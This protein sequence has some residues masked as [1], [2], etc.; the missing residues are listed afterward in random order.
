MK[1]IEFQAELNGS[2]VLQ[3][4]AE[5][6]SKLPDHGTATV[7]VVVDGEADDKAWRQAAREQFMR[8]DSKADA[9]Y[10]RYL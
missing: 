1:P 9:S 3:I 8:D 6:A 10:D 4:P 2:R 5:I 7:V